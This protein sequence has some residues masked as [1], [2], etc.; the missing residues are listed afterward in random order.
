MSIAQRVMLAPVWNEW[1]T[2]SKTKVLPPVQLDSTEDVVGRHDLDGFPIYCCLPAGI[3]GVGQHQVAWLCQ[4]D[5]NADPVRLLLKDG[6]RFHS[7][8]CRAGWLVDRRC[9]AEKR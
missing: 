2:Y 4:I 9:M 1:E 5:L 3:I 8:A 6:R 7:G